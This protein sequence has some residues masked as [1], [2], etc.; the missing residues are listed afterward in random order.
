MKKIFLFTLLW[1]HLSFGLDTLG[2]LD[3]Y[4]KIDRGEKPQLFDIG[5]EIQELHDIMVEV[6]ILTRYFDD[7]SKA[8]NYASSGDTSR[9]ITIC[10]NVINNIKNQYGSSHI[11][12]AQLYNFLASLLLESG[13]IEKSITYTQQGIKIFNHSKSFDKDYNVLI[14]LYNTM[15]SILLQQGRY[16]Q[17]I[18]YTQKSLQSAKQHSQRTSYSVAQ[19]HYYISNIYE[20]KYTR[21]NVDK[22]L[23][24]ALFHIQKSLEIYQSSNPKQYIDIAL[25][26]DSLASIYSKQNKDTLALKYHH[27]ALDI[28][29]KHYNENPKLMSQS[30]NSIALL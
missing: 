5:K 29:K 17:A 9:A 3:L 2:E 26:Y 14:S 10:Y 1:S 25:G 28:F 13:K 12:L 22:Y 7:L 15:A 19:T 4:K 24:Q 23:K 8:K 18:K 16:N 11:V 6:S 20:E 30:Y 27:K 21:Y